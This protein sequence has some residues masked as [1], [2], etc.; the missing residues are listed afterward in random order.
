L[1]FEPNDTTLGIARW[2]RRER[3]IG[4][5]RNRRGRLARGGKRE[6]SERFE[7][8]TTHGL[9]AEGIVNLERIGNERSGHLLSRPFAFGLDNLVEG[10]LHTTR[11]V[12]PHV[13]L[14]DVGST[15]FAALA[16]D[17]DEVVVAVPKV[18]GV[19]GN[20]R[21]SPRFDTF[22][23]ALDFLPSF[24]LGVQTLFDS[25]LVSTSESREDQSTGVWVTD[26]DRG[27]VA[28]ADNRDGLRE[29]G[30]VEL[31]RDTLGVEVESE[32]DEVDVSGT[33][34]ITQEASFN[35]SAASKKTILCSCDSSA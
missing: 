18:L 26:G 30:K 3:F 7:V 10:Y 33:F 24:L 27:L 31:G 6:E 17:T 19:D 5:I 29:V 8:Q 12:E 25:I 1:S 21:H 4:V 13:C 34:A 14:H 16:G 22:T 11:K 32:S 15:G 9:G 2:R 23:S 28:A 20:V 35:T